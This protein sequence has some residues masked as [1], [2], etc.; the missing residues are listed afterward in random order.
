MKPR[1]CASMKRASQCA[2]RASGST[3]AS[4]RATRA[5]T[6]AASVSSPLAYFS[7]STSREISCAGR[8]AA[9]G[10]VGRVA[11]AMIKR[12]VS[13]A[14]KRVYFLTLGLN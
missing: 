2:R 7:S 10:R 3:A 4:A 14:T 8:V 1:S 5:R 6:C 12:L 9:V 13:L 11:C